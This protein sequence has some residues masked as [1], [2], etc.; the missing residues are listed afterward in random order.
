MQ[1][2]RKGLLWGLVGLGLLAGA[3]CARHAISESLRQQADSTVS[4]A[5]L[6]GDPT[7]YTDRIVIVGGTI[8]ST[9]PV[10]HGTLVTVVQHPL[11][12]HERPRLTDATA[13]RFIA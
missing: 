13:G 10:E 11:D 2:W 1:G 5:A 12:H 6:E 7:A 3:G 4:F 8:V 9:E